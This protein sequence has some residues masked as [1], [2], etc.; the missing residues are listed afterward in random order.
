MHLCCVFSGPKVKMVISNRNW[1]G[2]FQNMAAIK[3]HAIVEIRVGE[4]MF[5]FHFL[6]PSSCFGLN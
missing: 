3:Q 1:D 2:F 6:L 4:G 5:V